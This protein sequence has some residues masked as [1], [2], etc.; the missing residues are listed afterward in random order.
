M[1]EPT[2]DEIIKA[3]KTLL[4]QTKNGYHLSGNDLIKAQH[5]VRIIVNTLEKAEKAYRDWRIENGNY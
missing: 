5:A 3:I 2:T 1:H 4:T